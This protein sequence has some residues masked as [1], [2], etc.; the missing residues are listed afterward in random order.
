MTKTK[1]DKQAKLDRAVAIERDLRRHIAEGVLNEI[2]AAIEY[3]RQTGKAWN[4]K[5][6]RC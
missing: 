3:A 2:E 1:T 5:H 6:E 4:W